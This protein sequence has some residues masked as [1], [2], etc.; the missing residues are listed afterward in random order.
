MGWAHL[1]R[2]E[3]LRRSDFDRLIKSMRTSMVAETGAYSTRTT[4]NLYAKWVALNGGRVRG[5]KPEQQQEY[6]RGT[7]PALQASSLTLTPT[8]S[9]MVCEKRRQWDSI[10]VES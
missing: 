2:Y 5:V 4:W 9:N 1:R 8:L 3:G 7:G 10:H 6:F